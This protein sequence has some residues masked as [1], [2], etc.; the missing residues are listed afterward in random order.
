MKAE[1]VTIS[2]LLGFKYQVIWC[3]SY[4]SQKC[5]AGLFFWKEGITFSDRY[6]TFYLK[7]PQNISTHSRKKK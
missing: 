6:L 3:M 4:E 2:L 5:Y 7:K 1:V